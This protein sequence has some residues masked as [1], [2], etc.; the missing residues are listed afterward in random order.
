MKR[1]L[2]SGFAIGVLATISAVY[3]TSDMSISKVRRTSIPPELIGMRA[4][5]TKIEALEIGLG[6]WQAWFVHT[7]NGLRQL[8]FSM[9]GQPGVVVG[10]LY[11]DNG[12]PVGDGLARAYERAATSIE[13]IEHLAAW[14]SREFENPPSVPETQSRQLGASLGESAPL[15]L[16]VD[17]FDGPSREQAHNI[18]AMIEEPNVRVIPVPNAGP[19]AFDGMHAIMEAGYISTGQATSLELFRRAL[20]GE[21]VM[22]ISESGDSEHQRSFMEFSKNVSLQSRLGVEFLPAVLHQAE[23]GGIEVATL[24]SWVSASAQL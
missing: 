11:D 20:E 19:G 10:D 8:V 6:D 2:I 5:K 17:P 22:P 7:S 15:Y 4:D 3:A 16:L 14:I 12:H 24:S 13:S 1:P 23:G 18:M 9:P 21:A